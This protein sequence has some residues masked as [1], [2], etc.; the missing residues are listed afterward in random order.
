MLGADIMGPEKAEFNGL[1]VDLWPRL[2]WSPQWAMTFAD[3][4]VPAAGVL[5]GIEL[6]LHTITCC[7]QSAAV[8]LYPLPRCLLQ[9]KVPSTCKIQAAVLSAG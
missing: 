2:S 6:P 9:S 4:Q 5:W 8:P 3:L 7:T 1:Q